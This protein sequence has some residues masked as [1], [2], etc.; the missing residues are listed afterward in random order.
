MNQPLY[1]PY[2]YYQTSMSNPFVG[3]AEGVY[4]WDHTGKQY[5]DGSSGAVIC[6]IGHGDKR[7]LEAINKQAEQAFFSYRTQFENE[8]AHRLAMKL[9]DLSA[10]HLSRVF[11]VSSGSEAVESALKL[12][13]Q[14]FYARGDS[15][16]LIISRFPSYHGAT[17][18]ALSLTSY[19][20]LE[21]PYRQ[22]L[23]AHPRIPAP[24]CY[25]CEYNETYP[26]CG[27]RCAWALEQCILDY[28]KRNIA[29]FIAEPVTGASGGAIVPPPDYFDVIQQICS[30]YN[31]L[32]ILDEVMTGYGRTGKFFA[33]EHWNVQADIIALSKGMGS[34]YFPLAATI[35]RREIVDAVMSDGGF[36]H[37]H[38]SAGAPMACAVGEKV[39]DIIVEDGLCGNAAAMGE[40]LGR[41]LRA[42][43]DK[44]EIIGD[45]RGIGLLWAV[46]FVADRETKEPFPQHW[47]VGSLIK[48]EAFEEGLIVYPRRSIN[49]ARGDHVLVAPPLIIN[50]EQVAELLD[51]LDKSLTRLAEQITGLR[52]TS[53][54]G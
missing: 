20:V 23:R 53:H 21:N 5:L 44:H 42:L 16:N 11:Y 38:T 2:L 1:T 29:A 37:G 41:G 9:I 52:E 4:I 32:F 27:L 51:R 46:E 12:C 26:D 18:G 47:N 6:N 28:G 33:Y 22:L 15:R 7:I 39:L 25:R 19:A 36:K 54:V 10:P 17:I 8:A 49:G 43:A 13:Q 50:R 3:R 14:Y 31:I 30:K 48:N 34:G 35:S 24:Y 40:I 45:V